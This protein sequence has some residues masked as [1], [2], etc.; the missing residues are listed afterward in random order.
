M[1]RS[2]A[3]AAYLAWSARA[4]PFAEGKLKARLADGKEDADRLPERKGIAGRARPKGRLIWIHC[5]SVGESISVLDVVRGLIE[6]DP[7]LNILMTSGTVTSAQLMAKQLPEQVIHQ[8]VPLD[9]TLFVRRFLDHWRP[10]LAVWTESEL[11]PS[12]IHHTHA[13]GIPLALI[14]ARM[15]DQSFSKWKWFSGAAASLLQRF[16]QI[17]AQD[18]ETARKLRR[19]G[20]KG[21][22]VRVTGTLKEGAAPPSCA[23]VERAAFAAQLAG[24]PCWLAA[25]THPGEEALVAQAHKYARRASLR[26][27]LILAPRHPERGDAIAADLRADGWNVAQRSADENL[28]E[29]TQIYLADTLGE[30]GLWFRVCPVTFLGGSLVPIGGH[31][32]FEPAGLG[33]AILTGPHTDN[34]REIFGRLAD[35]N[36]MRLVSSADDLGQ[37][38]DAALSPEEAARLAHAAWEVVSDGAEVVD[39]T[40]NALLAMIEKA[41]R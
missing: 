10:N 11:W 28:T 29:D 33:S 3:L 36:A 32:P 26:L 13:R 19:L 18:R 23:E 27:L 31:N 38:V 30:M 4:A 1:A 41:K 22:A 17:R 5:A 40:V 12:L 20:A 6:Q 7:D 35:G 15:S 2:L 16:D 37:Q 34:F 14:N 8:Y 21:S 39:E 25:S 9:A 24:R